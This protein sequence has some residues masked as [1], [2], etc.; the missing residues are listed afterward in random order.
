MLQTAGLLSGTLCAL[1]LGA[2][3]AFTIVQLADAE[4]H[5]ARLHHGKRFT[6]P[7]VAELIF[8]N[9]TIGG[10]NVLKGIVY[11]AVVM[12][13]IGACAAYVIFICTVMPVVI[14]DSLNSVSDPARGM[15]AHDHA[16]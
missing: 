6:Y 10:V 8:P 4:K 9:A 5:C 12:V 3:A 1:A 7:E 15:L 2:L 16:E 13:S 14:H 11:F